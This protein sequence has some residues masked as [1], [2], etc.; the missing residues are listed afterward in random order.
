M[1]AVPRLAIFQD[2]H[3]APILALWEA[4][5]GVCHIVWVIGWSPHK[6]APRELER[7]GEVVDLSGMS[8]DE[9]VERVV[10]ARPD[11]VVIFT[12]G[13]LLLAAAVADRLNLPFHSPEVARRLA[14]KILQRSALKDAGVAVPAFAAVRAGEPETEVPFPAVLKPRGGAGSRDTFLVENPRELADAIAKCD[15]GEQFILEEWLPDRAVQ[16]DL[17]ADL[18]SVESIVRD[19]AIKHFM[20]AGRFPFAP[21]FRAT[22]TFL[23]SDLTPADRKAVLAAASAAIEALGIRHGIIDTE[24]KRTPD[25]PR[26][27]EVNGRMGGHRSAM[28]S[29]I[30]GPSLFEWA[31]RLALGEDIG[32]IPELPENPIAFF[33]MIVAPPTATSVETVVGLSEV[34]DLAGVDAVRLNRS[35]G[36]PVSSRE[37]SH[38]GH[39]VWIDGAVQSRAELSRLILQEIPAL[40]RLTFAS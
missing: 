17:A 36:D 27:V 28:V 22:G 10:A 6:V 7:F 16:E 3:S 38:L 25:G 40:L 21:P 34:R 13:P 30:G 11:G 35:P 31:M 29:R 26:I 12:D 15:S 1:A 24:I 19:G 37:S 23:P 18:V 9:S 20:V 2:E 32:P 14:D 5:R 4:A 8:F 33:R 39:V